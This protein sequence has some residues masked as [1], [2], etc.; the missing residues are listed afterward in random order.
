MFRDKLKQLVNKNP[1][2]GIVNN[3]KKIENLVTRTLCYTQ[4]PC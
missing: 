2:E 1:E 3:K 4:V